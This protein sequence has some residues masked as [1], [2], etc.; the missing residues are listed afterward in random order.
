ML[1]MDQIHNIREMFFQ[2]GKNISQIASET[3]LN[4][5]TVQKYVDMEDFNEKSPVKIPQP[6]SF[7]K[8][9]AYK[10]TIDSWLEADKKAKR[11]QRHTAKRVF[12]RLVKEAPGF[13]CSY[14]LIAD[15][16]AVKKKELQLNKKEGFIPLIH[17]PGEAQ[18]DFGEAE[19]VENGISHVGK[20]LVLSFP[21]SNAGY[22]QLHGGEN[23]ECLLE[24][25]VAIFNHMGGVPTE[26]WFD[27]T[28]T[29]VTEVIYGGGRTV[30]ERFKRFAE[31][32]GFKPV[33]MNP[34]AGWEKGNVE[35]KVGYDRRN[36]FV[37]VPHFI[38]LAD[39]NKTLFSICEE[40][41]NRPH[42]MHDDQ[43]IADIFKED[44][45][46]LMPLPSIEFETCG[47]RAAKTNNYGKF[48]L[49]G[50]YTYSCSPAQ[51][52]CDIVV[53]LTSYS[54]TA[55]DT[56]GKEIVAHA[57]LYGPDKQE[58]MQWLPY[59]QHI[60]HKPRSLNNSGIYTMLPK[61][62]QEYMDKCSNSDRGKVL[63]VLAELTDR[64]G[65]ESAVQ[66]IS[67]AVI[68]NATDPDSLMNLYRQLYSDIPVLPPLSVPVG[69]PSISQ[70]PADLNSYDKLLNRSVC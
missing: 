13:D 43:Q 11:K 51:A 31:H 28:K 53:K 1:T 14:R 37:P 57:R 27:N 65:F 63:R 32:Y 60:A 38:S 52:D 69:V 7:P 23:M 29:I 18:A 45:K 25:L 30:N 47:Y 50:K 20:Y 17:H 24:S 49:D 8:L 35:N 66:T 41:F 9:E 16:V 36:F 59:L 10:S 56:N 55:V 62:V 6:R 54:V 2:Q 21:Y 42:Y 61:V 19:Y 70:M 5:K 39:Y 26:I 4:W 22:V 12:N 33:F 15:Y 48:T 40:D 64:T 67:Q 46:E 68:Y 3:H 58:S 44:V 34:A